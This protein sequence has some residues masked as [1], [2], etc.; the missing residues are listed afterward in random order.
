M[1]SCMCT[2]R[3]RQPTRWSPSTT[4]PITHLRVARHS[5]VRMVYGTTVRLA[6]TPLADAPSRLGRPPF[7][8]SS[9]GAAGACDSSSEP[10]LRDR[11][12]VDDR[13]FVVAG[14]VGQYSAQSV[15]RARRGI[16]MAVCA[17]P[18]GRAG[19]REREH[20]SLADPIGQASGALGAA[21][22]QIRRRAV[23]PLSRWMR[24]VR[25]RRDVFH[26]G[27]SRD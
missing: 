20:R 24:D 4:Y 15:P 5:D 9:P 17:L 6:Q 11:G 13:R 12:A 19:I 7:G 25:A 22:A 8:A 18:A 3:A 2:K 16:V 1:T 14:R 23:R 26:R 27:R 21:P 10:D